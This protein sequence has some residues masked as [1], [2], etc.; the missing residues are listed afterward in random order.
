MFSQKIKLTSSDPSLLMLFRRISTFLKEFGVA[1]LRFR[2]RHDPPSDG[3]LLPPFID[4]LLLR[5]CIG[6]GRT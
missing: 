6:N 4:E 5:S 3:D 1:V 2:P